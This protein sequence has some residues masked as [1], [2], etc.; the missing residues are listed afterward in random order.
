M[1]EARDPRRLVRMLRSGALIGLRDEVEP[2][3][4]ASALAPEARRL[5]AAEVLVGSLSQ[6]RDWLPTLAG[7]GRRLGERL[8][9]GPVVLAGD[10][11]ALASRLPSAAR[12]AL[13]SPLCLRLASGAARA[14]VELSREP[15]LCTAAEARATVIRLT[16]EGWSMTREGALSADEVAR[17]LAKRLLFVCTGNTCRSP[18]AEAL[19]RMLL[20][21]RLGCGE[22]WRPR[23][24]LRPRGARRRRRPS[25]RSRPW[26]RTWPG[27]RAG[28][29][30][31]RRRPG[32]ITW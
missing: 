21:K 25:R 19:A 24:C 3:T 22:S 27:M 23:G 26:G 8:W 29:Y 16:P 11:G 17:R 28:R 15:L 14:V 20:A 31:Q 13:G 2:L 7:R 32:R 5:G 18:M 12:E 1:A 9:P 30:G 4:L 10:A 6:A